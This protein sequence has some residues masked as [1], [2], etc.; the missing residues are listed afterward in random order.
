VRAARELFPRAIVVAGGPANLPR[1]ADLVVANLTAAELHAAL[2][3]V[4]ARW[5]QRAA[6]VLSGMRE[7]EVASIAARD[8]RAVLRT[9]TVG[10]FTAC[11]FAPRPVHG[12][13]QTSKRTRSPR[14][15]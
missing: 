14:T 6:L 1:A 10:A 3:D 4:L 9:E 13:R 5:N 2:D 15:V 12:A 11:A 8:R 7:G